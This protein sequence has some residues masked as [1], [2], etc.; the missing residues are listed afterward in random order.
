MKK[1]IADINLT[2]GQLFGRLSVI[3]KAPPYL[4]PRGH[5]IDKY[6]MLCECGTLR[7]IRKD[8]LLSGKTVS[9]GCYNRDKQITHGLSKSKEHSIWTGMKDRSLNVNSKS[10]EGYQRRGISIS[11]DWKDFEKF[12]SDMGPCPEGHTLH[13]IDNDGMYCKENC[14]W[15]NGS[16][17]NHVKRNWGSSEYKG[18]S[19]KSKKDYYEACIR[20]DGKYKY[21]G[22]SK[23]ALDCAVLYDNASE[24]LYGDRP[25]GTKR[26]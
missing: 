23:N 24:E 16:L 7:A 5:T 13:R 21:L 26:E 4:H 6:F 8:A 1:T 12:F 15:D 22:K 14:V 2:F 3:T 19:Y 17:Q 11:E 10:F 9:C 25:N 20:K 18:V